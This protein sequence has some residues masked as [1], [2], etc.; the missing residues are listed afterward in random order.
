MC[1]KENQFQFIQSMSL[2]FNQ[3]KELIAKNKLKLRET[4]TAFIFNEK[5]VLKNMRQ[6]LF[7][8]QLQC[9]WKTIG[10]VYSPHYLHENYKSKDKL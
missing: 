8:Q 3:T 4:S 9:G 10:K 1:S 2:S 6:I 5:R 7:T